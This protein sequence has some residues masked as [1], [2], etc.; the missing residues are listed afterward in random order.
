[1]RLNRWILTLFVLA[2]VAVPAAAGDCDG[3]PHDQAAA[4]AKACCAGSA[5][6]H[7]CSSDC[8]HAQEAL[9]LVE[10]AEKGDAAAMEKLVAMI[11][12]SGHEDAIMLADKAAGGCEAS[13]AKLM[14]MVK[15]HVGGQ[16]AAQT[17]DMTKMA[18]AAGMGC[19]KST[20]GL[21]AAAKKSDDPK[22]VELATA[23]EGGCQRSKEALI[24]MVD[25]ETDTKT[26]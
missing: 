15:E 18:K 13:Q 25:Q 20:A 21:I 4:E 2:L 17:A 9:Q 11:K 14:A 23:A 16:S 7:G 8:R 12:E 10:A 6:G 3:K 19:A 22:M 1:M 5:E 26:E 24:A